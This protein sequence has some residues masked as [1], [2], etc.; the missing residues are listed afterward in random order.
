VIKFGLVKISGMVAAVF[1]VTGAAAWV[2]ITYQRADAARFENTA[3]ASS[4]TVTEKWQNFVASRP[5]PTSSR[6]V[7]AYRFKT[8]T[9]VAFDGTD[10]VD[11]A[12]WNP[13]KR[14]D[15]IRVYYLPD[16]PR[17]SHLRLQSRVFNESYWVPLALV[18]FVGCLFAVVF[19]L[20][21]RRA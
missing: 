2:F 8:A 18:F 1:L 16:A 14:G 3:E 11:A 13:L 9:G 17:V 10:V 5:G 7:V 20:L 6:H 12:T 19:I 21:R 15:K 4:G